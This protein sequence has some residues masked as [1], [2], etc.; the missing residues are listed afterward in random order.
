MSAPPD[1]QADE[2]VSSAEY[3]ADFR[4]DLANFVP[5]DV[6]NACSVPLVLV[7]GRRGG[8]RRTDDAA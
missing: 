4:A 5:W 6:M 3:A 1:W 7:A 2:P 8:K